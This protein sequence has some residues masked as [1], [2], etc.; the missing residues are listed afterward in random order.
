LDYDSKFDYLCLDISQQAK[1]D[2]I[3]FIQQGTC[4]KPWQQ[5]QA[6]HLMTYR[7]EFTNHAESLG[8]H[9]DEVLQLR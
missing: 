8:S 9:K 6:Y 1:T 3:R 7:A 4:Q 2:E 5:W